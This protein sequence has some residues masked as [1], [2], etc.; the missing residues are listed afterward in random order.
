MAQGRSVQVVTLLMLTAR[1]ALAAPDYAVSARVT[2]A[3]AAEQRC[4]KTAGGGPI[5]CGVLEQVRAAFAAQA[6]KMFKAGS[7]PG[8]SLVVTVTGAEIYEGVGGGLQFDLRV[9]TSVLAAGDDPVDEIDSVA[10]ITVTQETTVP[11]AGEVA[12]RKAAGDFADRFDNSKRV[13]AWLIKSGF[14]RAAD[15]APAARGDKLV[16]FAVGG[17]L[18][19]GG[20]DGAAGISPNLR[21]AVTVKWIMLQLSYAH[22]HSTF[23]GTSRDLTFDSDLS[24]H[25]LGL[26]AGAVIRLPRDVELQVGPGVHALFSSADGNDP[27]KS[28]PLNGVTSSITTLA[29]TAFASISVAFAP[30][31]NGGR[32]VLGFEARGYASTTLDLHEFNRSVPVVN[33]TFGVF[34][35]SE[36]P[37]GWKGAA[38]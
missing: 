36:I 25:D 21:V 19:Q 29:P 26:E 20:G 5:D 3:P 22:F 35:G 7:S 27:F 1:G 14:A 12:A 17:A 38:R 15:L 4:L 28:F 24:T 23:Q 18:A 16:W 37:W 11:D 8:L 31:R 6:A 9:T 13:H 10:R 2:L 30:F 32:L 33:S 34:F